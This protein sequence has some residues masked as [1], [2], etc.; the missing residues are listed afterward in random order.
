MAAKLQ[1]LEVRNYYNFTITFPTIW[2]CASDFF[3]GFTEIQNGHHR[4]TSIFLWVQKL[5][6]LK[7]KIV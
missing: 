3:Q 7:S 4:L 2:R 5:E 1:K 6:D